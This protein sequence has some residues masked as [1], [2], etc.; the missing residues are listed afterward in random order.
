T[1]LKQLILLPQV[2]KNHGRWSKEHLSPKYTTNWNELVDV[3]AN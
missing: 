3:L 1:G 2:L